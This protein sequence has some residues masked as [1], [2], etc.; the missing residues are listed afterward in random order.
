[1]AR[2]LN[3]VHFQKSSNDSRVVRVQA[4]IVDMVPAKRKIAN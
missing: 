4:E 2:L 1:M 3:I